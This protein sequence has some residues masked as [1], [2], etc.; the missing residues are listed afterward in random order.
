LSQPPRLV[1][2]AGPNGSGK[3]T[4]TRQWDTV[5]IYV[6]ADDIKQALD[7]D[8]IEAAQ[9]AERVR[10]LCLAEKRD[11]TF[12]T[13]LSTDRNL[14]LLA[15]AAAIGYLITGVFILTSDPELN[16]FRVRSRVLSGGHEVPTDKIRAR[17][18]RSLANIPRF[19]AL[20]DEFSLFDNTEEPEILFFKDESGSDSYPRPRWSQD[21]IRR[22]L[23]PA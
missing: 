13:V 3:S 15:R 16:V 21:A 7:C 9:Q 1:V 12:E 4:I 10:E 14:D 6:N 20:C 19:A 23:S 8:D 18:R 22:L 5:G 11:F 2:F 17:Y